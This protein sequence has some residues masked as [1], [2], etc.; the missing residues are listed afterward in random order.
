[1]TI[2]AKLI[3][4]IEMD[5]PFSYS[6]WDVIYL[7]VFADADGYKYIWKTST[8]PIFE[9]SNVFRCGNTFTFDAT[10][11]ERKEY[12]G[13]IETVVTRCKN[14]VLVDEYKPVPKKRIT[15]EEQLA[16]LKDGDTV[17]RMAYARYKK[18]YSDC[19]TVVDSFET[20]YGWDGIERKVIKV[21]IRDGRMVASGTRGKEFAY[22][23]FQS[24]AGPYVDIKAI[25]LEN[26]IKRAPKD[27]VYIGALTRRLHGGY[28]FDTDAE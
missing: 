25:T 13:E 2:T 12:K 23:R 7:N 10:F 17:I 3:K 16:T 8:T 21:I 26:A 1:M 5:N 20:L 11:K 18:H 14:F 22:Y 4:R 27:S 19:E 24:P 9:K 6:K 28:G 15:A